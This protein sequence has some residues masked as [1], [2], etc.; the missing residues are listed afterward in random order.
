[1]GYGK[2]ANRSEETESYNVYKKQISDVHLWLA[3]YLQ[4]NGDFSNRPNGSLKINIDG[5]GVIQTHRNP[6]YRWPR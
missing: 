1:M 2:V 5:V 6:K 3:K 4:T